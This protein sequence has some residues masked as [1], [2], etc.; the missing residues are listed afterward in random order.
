MLDNY[1]PIK[2]PECKYISLKYIVQYEIIS[3][4]YNNSKQY[5]C[6]IKIIDKLNA[7]KIKRRHHHD[8][9]IINFIFKRTPGVKNKSTIYINYVNKNI[10]QRMIY[11]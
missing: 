7:Q 8:T 1:V 6:M 9:K 11:Q 4:K 3:I 5:R 10:Y 2:S